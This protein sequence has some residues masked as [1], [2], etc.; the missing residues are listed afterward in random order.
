MKVIVSMGDV[1]ASGGYYIATPASTIFAEKTTITGSIGVFGVIPYTGKLFE[2]KL[3]ITF[4]RAQTNA[5][6]VLSTNRKLTPVEFALVQ[7]EVDQIY[8]QFKKRVADGRGMTVEQVDV[9]ARGR[10]WTGTD[11][12]RIGL[13]DKI[14]GLSDAIA[15]AVKQ[16]GI[17]KPE[18]KYW[19][20]IDSSPLDDLLEQLSESES[21]KI[22]SRAQIPAEFTEAYE[23]L[24]KLDEMTGIQMRLPFG[25]SIR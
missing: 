9:I 8:G 24:L 18:I 5:H 6:S 10:V 13:V 12:L 17:K 3:G 21:V 19:P 4:D 25:L 2:E 16:S 14:G 15:Y 23:K 7:A 11:A 1:A 20:V 22:K